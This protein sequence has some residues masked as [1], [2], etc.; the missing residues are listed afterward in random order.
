MPAIEKGVPMRTFVRAIVLATAAALVS[1]PSLATEENFAFI[2]RMPSPDGTEF[3]TV[4]QQQPATGMVISQTVFR[5]DLPDLIIDTYV[6][7][8]G[9]E[10]GGKLSADVE[11][12]IVAVKYKPRNPKAFA[13]AMLHDIYKQVFVRDRDDK[14][15]AY[16]DLNGREMIDLTETFKPD[17]PAI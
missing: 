6:V 2:E 16:D 7:R 13:V 3:K 12:Y 5:Q 4:T 11:P 15:R 17:C 14:V 8:A 10:A 9:C 1:G